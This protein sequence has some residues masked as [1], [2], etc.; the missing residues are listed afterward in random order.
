M[1]PVDVTCAL[2]FVRN[3]H[4]HPKQKSYYL[5]LY[6]NI[7]SCLTNTNTLPQNRGICLQREGTYIYLWLMHVDVWQKPTKFCK[8][9]ILKLKNKYIKKI[10]I[11]ITTKRNLLKCGQKPL[12]IFFLLLSE[13]ETHACYQKP[14][15][16]FFLFLSCTYMY[17]IIK[18][19]HE[20]SKTKF[21]SQFFST[22][23]TK[24]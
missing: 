1:A 17:H 23:S 7:P 6:S 9:I 13:T 20:P 24:K 21:V 16:M 11:T 19:Q 15:Q 2:H 4:L 12:Q 10:V 22:T 14:L 5:N 8:A 3:Q 18:I